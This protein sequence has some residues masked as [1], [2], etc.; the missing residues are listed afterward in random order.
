MLI[1]E[2][3]HTFDEKN[4]ISLPSK[5]RK[6]LGRNVVVTHGLDNCLFIFPI[7]EWKKLSEKF[8]R[9]GMGQADTRGF[10]RFM[11]AGAV[12]VEV[13]SIGR[14][15]IADFQREFAE[16]KSKVV[17][18]G[19]YSRVE[20]W[21]EKRWLEYKARIQTQADSLAEKLGQIGMV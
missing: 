7:K 21:N 16:L 2:Y 3:T 20:V 4:R 18:T 10:N 14:I 19:V 5:F 6:E 8:G 1:G 11:L 12:E 17:F 9:L 15:L 13:D